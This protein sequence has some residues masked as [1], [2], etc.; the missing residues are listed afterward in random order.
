MSFTCL[1]SFK[2]NFNKRVKL[3]SFIVLFT[4]L[5]GLNSYAKEESRPDSIGGD[6]IVEVNNGIVFE[7]NED[8]YEIGFDFE[9]FLPKSRHHFSIGL[10]TEIQVKEHMQ[11]YIGPLFSAYY[12]HTK[13]FISAGLLTDFD[14][15]NLFRSRLGLGYEFIFANHNIIIPTVTIDVDHEEVSW[16]ILIGLAHEF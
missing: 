9:Y 4:L 1:F 14:G 7:E 10:A 2:A 3:W 11:Y 8:V 15:E 5:M 13:L 12:Y 16:G 6:Y